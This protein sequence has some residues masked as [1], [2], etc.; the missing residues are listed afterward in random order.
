MEREQGNPG[1]EPATGGYL[2]DCHTFLL[3]FNWHSGTEKISK[4]F[5][6]DDMQMAR[7]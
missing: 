3:I 7:E 6:K 5:R 2:E 1:A 4:K